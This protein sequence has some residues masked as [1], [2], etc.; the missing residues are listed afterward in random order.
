[1]RRPRVPPSL[2]A[3]LA[4][5]AAVLSAGRLEAQTILNVERFQL[6][7]VRGFHVSADLSVDLQ[8]GNSEVLDLGGSGV[9]GVLEGRHWPRVIFG[10]RFLSDEDRSVLDR[11]FV[12]LRYSYILTRDVRTFHFVQAQRNETLLLRARWLVGSGIRSSF[13]DTDRVTASVGTGLMGE[14]ERL[15]ADALGPDDDR[16]LR[17]LR[18]ANLAT[19]SVTMDR[20]VRILNIVYLQ[21]DIGELRDMRILNDLGLFLP[22][23]DWLHATISLEWRR[24]TRPPSTL[25]RDDVSLTMGFGIEIN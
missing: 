16:R 10:G 22:I 3:P 2:L 5:L 8:R 18:I 6:A 20:G 9:V 19:L 24:D 11:Q 21:P 13:V 15:E 23:R 4:L 1:M 17:A 25:E 12:Q 14:W 7:D